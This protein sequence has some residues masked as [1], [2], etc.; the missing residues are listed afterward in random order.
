[1]R[2]GYRAACEA[3]RA[4]GCAE[5][6]HSSCASLKMEQMQPVSGRGGAFLGLDPAVNHGQMVRRTFQVMYHPALSAL[7]IH[8]SA[9]PVLP[10]SPQ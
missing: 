3:Q 8:P 7:D 1:M 5:Q 10:L 2:H 4:P 6:Q 9:I